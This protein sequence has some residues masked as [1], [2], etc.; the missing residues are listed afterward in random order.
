MVNNRFVA[1]FQLARHEVEVSATGSRS[2]ERAKVRQSQSLDLSSWKY[3]LTHGPTGEVAEGTI[4]E[5]QPRRDH[6]VRVIMFRMPV[7]R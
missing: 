6:Q 7:Q 3:T 4:P 5:N 1:L 2:S